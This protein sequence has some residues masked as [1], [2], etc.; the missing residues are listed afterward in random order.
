MYN[1]TLEN[2]KTNN[3]FFENDNL[4]NVIE[5]YHKIPR[6]KTPNSIII[7]DNFTGEIIKMK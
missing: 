7:L 5:F 6:R 3:I 4:K 2:C 1:Y